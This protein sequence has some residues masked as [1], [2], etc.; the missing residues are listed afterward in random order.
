MALLL[1]VLGL[2]FYKS[3]G[4][5]SNF[6]TGYNFNKANLKASFDEERMCKDYGKRMMV[7]SVPFL[8]GA[9]VDKFKPGIGCILAWI[10]YTIFLIWHIIDRSKNERNRYIL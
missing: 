10:A 7:W 5:A 6:L 9:A 8:S 3:K 4:K 1:F 2:C